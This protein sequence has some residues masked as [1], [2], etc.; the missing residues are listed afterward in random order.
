MRADEV[1]RLLGA[2]AD[3]TQIVMLPVGYYKGSSFGRATRRA[4]ADAIHWDR[5]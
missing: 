2:P 5:W 3:L 1:G 4:A